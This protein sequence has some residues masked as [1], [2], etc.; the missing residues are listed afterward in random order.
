VTCMG[1]WWESQK[2]RD[3]LEDQRRRREDG[4]RMDLRETGW[5]CGVDS[6]GSG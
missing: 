6:I 2:E 3:H 4:I 1:F 5:G